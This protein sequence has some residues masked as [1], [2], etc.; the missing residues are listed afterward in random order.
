MKKRFVI[1]YNGTIKPFSANSQEDIEKR[2]QKD[3]N[4]ASDSDSEIFDSCGLKIGF[5][6]YAQGKV[7]IMPLEVWFENSQ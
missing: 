1:V 4:K 7:N 6:D 3:W 2:M 5:Q